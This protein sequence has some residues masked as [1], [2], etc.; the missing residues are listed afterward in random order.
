MGQEKQESKIYHPRFIL[1]S[2]VA[3]QV[4]K[5]TENIY[6]RAMNITEFWKGCLGLSMYLWCVLPIPLHATDII[7][8][9]KGCSGLS[10]YLWCVL[11]IPLHLPIRNSFLGDYWKDDLK[12]KQ[13]KKSWNPTSTIQRSF[14]ELFEKETFKGTCHKKSRKIQDL[15][16]Q[17]SFLEFFEEETLKGTCDKKRKNSRSTIQGSF[18]P[19]LCQDRCAKLSIE[20]TLEPGIKLNIEKDAWD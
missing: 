14:L 1:T 11:P 8:F 9:W 10:V 13:N 6:S 20:Y 2:T 16:I 4:R 12:G 5:T 19:A 17:S 7:E 3:G 15:T 18:S